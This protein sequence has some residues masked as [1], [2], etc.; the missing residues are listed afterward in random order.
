MAKVKGQAKAKP[1]GKAKPTGKT[2]PVAKA[3]QALWLQLGIA[4]EQAA[5]LALKGGLAVVMDTC[6]GATHRRLQIPR[7]S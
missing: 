2:R 5:S 3:T 7:K 4:N 1:A 6:I